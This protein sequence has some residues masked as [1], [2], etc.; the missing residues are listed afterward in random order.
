MSEPRV[1]FPVAPTAIEGAGGKSQ[2][3]ILF[4]KQ[5]IKGDLEQNISFGIAIKLSAF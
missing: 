4:F 2:L 1:N 3:H 5:L